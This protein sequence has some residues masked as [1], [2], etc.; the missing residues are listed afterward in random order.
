MLSLDRSDQNN[1]YLSPLTENEVERIHEGALWTLGQTGIAIYDERVLALLEGAGC[2]ISHESRR[3]Y[4]QE[5]V[6]EEALANAPQEFTLYDRLGQEVI[7]LGSG[8]FS[9]RISSGATGILDIDSDLRREPTTQDVVDAVRLAD[10]L[11]HIHGVSTMAVQPVDVPVKSIDLEMVKLALAYSIKPL[12][13][14]CLNEDHIE[15]VLE[16]AATVAGGFDILR[17]RPFITA[18]AEST[19][20]LRLAPSQMKVLKAFALRGLPL[21]LHAHPIA[22]LSAPV[23]MAGELVITHAE[24]LAL[25]TIAQLLR[26]GTPMV[27]GMSS[28]VPDMRNGRNLSGA[29]EIGLLGTAAA[30]LASRIR[31]PCVMSSG[32]DAFEPGSQSMLERLLTLLPP[33]LAGIDMINLSTLETK[34][35]FSPVQLVLDDTLLGFVARLMKGITVNDG[36]LALD[37][38]AALGS[39]GTYIKS[40]HTRKHFRDELLTPG[41][42]DH[43]SRD[44]WVTSGKPTMQERAREKVH[45]ILATH[46]PPPLTDSRIEQLDE[47]VR[48]AIHRGRST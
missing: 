33:A 46:H 5:K 40:N 32:T 37:L 43:E 44:A 7:V 4:L 26:P 17:E 10:A 24:V 21:T 36:T 19:S 16:M 1:A 8:S 6:I 12:G 48:K 42:I 9:A 23:T 18:L 31:I 30:Q 27:Y 41:L 47:I 3:A 35:T 20:P 34:M 29:V 2:S 25:V 22:G 14:V 11:P 39:E 45:H 28:S 13:Y 38:I 15:A